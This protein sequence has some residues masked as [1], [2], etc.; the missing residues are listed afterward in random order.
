MEWAGSK[1]LL[2]QRM[3]RLQ[4]TDDVQFVDATTGTVRTAFTERDAAWLDLVDDVTW[5]KD[6]KHFL[7]LSERD[8]WRHVYSVS[9]RRARRSW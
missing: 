6:N 8:G 7:W 2:L 3:N 4:N 5:L 9:R 1:E